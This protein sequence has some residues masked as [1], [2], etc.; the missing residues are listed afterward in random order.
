MHANSTDDQRYPLYD[1]RWEHDACGTG[2]VAQVSGKASH[3]LIEVALQALVNLTHR[4]AQDADSET[5][6]G[7]GIQTQIPTAL[8]CAELQELNTSL[9]DPDDLAVGMIF[10][11]APSAMQSYQQSRSIIEQTSIESGLI[12]L[13][14]REPPID[15]SIPGARA[16]A[17]APRIMQILLARPL[18]LTIKQYERTLYHTRRLI[19]HRLRDAHINDCY[20]ASFS[21]STIV[22]KG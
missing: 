12:L 18:H 1:S 11:P 7:A 20:I 15:Y 17:T 13:G 19:E 10:L 4:G 16:R 21:C 14:W 3:H 5:S 8:L 6:D 9:P 22:Y 2:F